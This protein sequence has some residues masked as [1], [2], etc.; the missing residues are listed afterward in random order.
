MAMLNSS[1]LLLF[2]GA[3]YFTVAQDVEVVNRN[4]SLTLLYQNNLNASDDLNHVG[5]VLLDSSPGTSGAQSCMSIKQTL[6]PVSIAQ[7]QSS[8]LALS[9][10]YQQYAGYYSADEEYAISGQVISSSGSGN[11]TYLDTAMTSNGPVICTDSAIQGSPQ[12]STAGPDTTIS[13]V[14]GT[15]TYTGYFNKK[16]F[17]FNGIKY[18][19]QPERFGFSTLYE[20]D[21]ETIN[22]TAYGSQCIQVGGGSEDCLFL[23][24]QTPYIPEAGSEKNLR[25]VMFWIHGG[26]S[27]MTLHLLKSTKFFQIVR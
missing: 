1:V 24:V 16:S 10:A 25:P 20:P 23:N 13:I 15:N 7:D 14:G 8:D 19:Q 12:N 2:L 6:L 9:L 11:L 4:T 26:K 5:F 17:R 27:H 22:A 21:E 18:A 3:G